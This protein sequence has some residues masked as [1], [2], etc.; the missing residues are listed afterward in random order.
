MLLGAKAVI[1]VDV[2]VKAVAEQE[3][4]QLPLG[5]PFADVAQDFAVPT[6]GPS[7]RF[8]APGFVRRRLSNGLGLRI[9]ERHDVPLASLTLTI[10][11]GETSTPPG[12]EGLCPFTT[13]L[14]VQGTKSRSAMEIAGSLSEIGGTIS[15]GGELEIMD[16]QP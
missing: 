3:Q 8:T 6:I 12:K 10:K 1:P 7:P 14:L 16:Y 4:Q 11:S 2:E 13:A 5:D 15:A 9:V